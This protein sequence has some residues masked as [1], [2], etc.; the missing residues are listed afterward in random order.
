MVELGTNQQR[1]GLLH[2]PVMFDN[3]FPAEATQ[4][5]EHSPL[6]IVVEKNSLSTRENRVTSI[7]KKKQ[8]YVHQQEKTELT[9]YQQ[10][11]TE[12]RPSTRENRVNSLSTREN[13]VT[14]I[15][16]RTQS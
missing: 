11:K 16:K 3:V 6:Q 2:H 15:N 4:V 1:R 9:A 10:E 8:S 14:S 7:N 13:R 5:L 12:L